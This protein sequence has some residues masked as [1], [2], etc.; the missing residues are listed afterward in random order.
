MEARA[1]AGLTTI[2]GAA[3]VRLEQLAEAPRVTFT[4]EGREQMLD[5]DFI[6]GCDGYHG[7]SRHSVPA[8]AL[9]V[10]EQTAIPSAWLGILADVPPADGELIYAQHGREERGF[11]LSARCGRRRCSRYTCRS[12]PARKAEAWSDVAF[13]DELLSAA[14]GGRGVARWLRGHRS[15]EVG[16]GAALIRSGADAVRQ[17]VS[18]RRRGAHRAADR[19]EGLNLAA[20]DVHYLP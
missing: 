6:A 13:W 9:S 3:D 7:V 5:C 11:T 12:M 19:G 18:L 16:G 10:F 4:A 8:D 2:Y 17:A 1:A 14:A 20:S 15:K